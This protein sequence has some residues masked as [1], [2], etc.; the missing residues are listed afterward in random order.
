MFTQFLRSAI[1]LCLIYGISSTSGA[2][3]EAHRTRDSQNIDIGLNSSTATDGSTIIDQ[4]VIINGLTMRFKISAPATELVGV[5]GTNGGNGTFGL[6]VL[7][8]GDGG[9]SFFDFPN[10]GVNNNLMGVA[11]LA[12][13]SNLSWGGSDSQNQTGFVR[14]DGAAHSTAVNQL[15]T[16]GIT[17]F[18]QLRP[19]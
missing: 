5:N 16:N 12:P 14:P 19:H 4:Q 18:R 1:F 2:P 10:Q 17:E 15:L 11:L 8:H 13:D 9:Q 7:F 3:L 6:N